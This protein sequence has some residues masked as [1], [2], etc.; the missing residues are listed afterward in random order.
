MTKDIISSDKSTKKI[1]IVDDD[2]GTR[3]MIRRLLTIERNYIIEEAVNG[4][5]AQEKLKKFKADLIVLDVM[6]PEKDGY[7]TCREIRDDLKM[8]NVKIIGISGC[9]GEIGKI[10]IEEYGADRFLEKPFTLIEFKET[11]S[12]LL[13]EKRHE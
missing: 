10:F 6:M 1:L 11:I 9:P 5:D 8:N 12:K 3:Y 2:E 7:K 4:N 13:K